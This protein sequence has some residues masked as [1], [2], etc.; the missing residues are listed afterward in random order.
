MSATH[1]NLLS[2]RVSTVGRC[3]DSSA[4]DDSRRCR[5]PGMSE[6]TLSKSTSLPVQPALVA[7]HRRDGLA[8]PAQLCASTPSRRPGQVLHLG[9]GCLAGKSTVTRGSICRLLYVWQLP[10]TALCARSITVHLQRTYW[11]RL[12]GCQQQTMRPSQPTNCFELGPAGFICRVRARRKRSDSNRNGG[13]K[14][15]CAV[16][17]PGDRCPPRRAASRGFRP[18]GG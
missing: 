10:R 2:A 15:G 6:K 14:P 17:T 4:S 1:T 3:W 8:V 7:S 11:R 9:A 12:L 16:V 13:R 5:W 18:D